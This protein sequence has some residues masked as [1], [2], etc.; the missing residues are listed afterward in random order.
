MKIGKSKSGDINS[1]NVHDLTTLGGVLPEL[2]TQQKLTFASTSGEDDGDDQVQIETQTCAGDVTQNGN[3]EV[4]FTG[5]YIAR[6]PITVN[7]AVL[8]GDTP[9]DYAEKIRV[10]LKAFSNSAI[11]DVYQVSGAGA[12]IVLTALAATVNDGTLNIA[13]MKG[14][15]DGITEKPTSTN[16]QSGFIGTG[17]HTVLVSGVSEAG[18]LISETVTLNGTNN[19]TTN[20]KF[21]RVNELRVMTTG[22]AGKTVG[23][24]TAKYSGTTYAELIAGE[25]KSLYG[26]FYNGT[27]KQMSFQYLN[28]LVQGSDSTVQTTIHIMIKRPG[29]P[30]TC[31]YEYTQ[32]GAIAQKEWTTGEDLPII[33]A[34]AELK[35]SAHTSPD[36]GT[37]T[38]TV[39][40]ELK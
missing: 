34:G 28:M 17:A 25:N 24:V 40:F 22:T 2:S 23:N 37:A 38:C 26:Y 36:T 10:S 8:N 9:A 16:T 27:G 11:T 13:V 5:A 31:E 18:R 12:N 21:F 14:T 6:S 15:S 30:Y 29:Q 32:L 3:L 20:T 35:F 7:V 19:V 1:S 33:P 4:T 39:N